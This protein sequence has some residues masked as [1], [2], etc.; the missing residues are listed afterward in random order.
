MQVASLYG[1]V[2]PQTLGNHLV[3]EVVPAGIFQTR[4]VNLTHQSKNTSQ[5]ISLNACCVF[6]IRFN[7]LLALIRHCMDKTIECDA[8]NHYILIAED[9]RNKQTMKTLVKLQSLF[10]RWNRRQPAQRI[11]TFMYHNQYMVWKRFWL[12]SIVN[13]RQICIS[14]YIM[15]TLLQEY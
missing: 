3:L 11:I 9:L 15:N 4:R 12:K 14:C 13:E 8:F 7:W 10:Y 5:S 6:H 2:N 1:I